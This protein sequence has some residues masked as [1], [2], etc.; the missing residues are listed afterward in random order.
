M[1]YKKREKLTCSSKKP[2]SSGSRSSWSVS[3]SSSSSVSRESIEKW[4]EEGNRRQF[5]GCSTT[6]PLYYCCSI[7]FHPHRSVCSRPRGFRLP[8]LPRSYSTWASWMTATSWPNSRCSPWS[9]LNR[10]PKISSLSRWDGIIP[11]GWTEGFC[12]YSPGHPDGRRTGKRWL[13][14]GGDDVRRHWTG[15]PRPSVIQRFVQL[16]QTQI[17]RFAWLLIIRHF[18][19]RRA[20]A[21]T[22]AATA[23]TA[24]APT[25]TA[26]FDGR[27]IR[28]GTKSQRTGAAVVLRHGGRNRRS[29]RKRF[30]V[31]HSRWRGRL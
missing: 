8:L 11:C 20:D 25:G 7:V 21:A 3:R 24:T 1:K 14:G 27:R 31:V 17:A 9:R 23:A 26:G 29:G 28:A 2:W 15:F 4:E 6:I 16:V 10:E 12:L 13:A 30:G 22:T 5:Q 19:G 18:A